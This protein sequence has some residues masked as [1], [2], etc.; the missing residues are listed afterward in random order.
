MYVDY[1]Q[2][3]E[4]RS[5]WRI[6][7]MLSST[8]FE[9][10]FTRVK[11]SVIELKTALRDY[12][13]E[14]T[15]QRQESQLG[16]ISTLQ[17][18]TN[19]KLNSMDEQLVL[20]RAMLAAQEAARQKQEDEDKAKKENDSKTEVKEEVERI[21]QNIQ[22]AAGVDANSPVDFRNFVLIFETFFYSG[23][24]MPSEQRRGLNIAV[25]RDQTKFVTKAAW[26]K[27][28][29]QW[30]EANIEIE[31]YL[32]KIAAENPTALKATTAK[33]KAMAAQGVGKAKSTLAAVGIESTDDAKKKIAEGLNQ[34]GGKFGFGKKQPEHRPEE[35]AVEA[36]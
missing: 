15:Q 12:L 36:Q 27:F 25:D 6:T 29:H 2:M 23:C 7:K 28:Y 16:E 35:Q 14:E 26:I 19:E 32:N 11:T 13:D 9:R 34:L 30:N 21:Y 20:I 33:A 22:R 4:W 8:T 1:Q 31:A 5:R 24:D 18:E 3:D 10:D 17:V